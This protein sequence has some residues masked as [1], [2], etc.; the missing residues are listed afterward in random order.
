MVSDKDWKGPG[1]Y[2]CEGEFVAPWGT[3]DNPFKQKAKREVAK[4]NET[5][6][7]V[8]LVGIGFAIGSFITHFCS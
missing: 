6:L 4:V 8:Q 3:G 5:L 7:R 2:S 1:W